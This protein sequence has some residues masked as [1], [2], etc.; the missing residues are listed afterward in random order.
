MDMKINSV[1]ITD[2]RKEKAWSQQHLADVAGLSL[3]TVQ[4]IE[5]TGTASQDS[6]KAIAMAFDMLPAD[7]MVVESPEMLP[8]NRTEP[9]ESTPSGYPK[10]LVS[11]LVMGGFLILGGSLLAAS[12]EDDEAETT[13]AQYAVSSPEEQHIADAAL[14]WLAVLDE[15]QFE[16]SWENTDAVVKGQVTAQQWAAAVRAGREPMGAFKSRKVTGIQTL[17]SVPGLPD[18]EYAIVTFSSRFANKAGGTET[19]SLSKSSGQWRLIG[20]FIR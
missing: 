12:P 17:S 11:A 14:R 10:A 16:Q 18:G 13:P 15:G 19:A 3:R 5:N 20:Y 2:I 7:L 6:V 8:A 9:T 4:R 1:R